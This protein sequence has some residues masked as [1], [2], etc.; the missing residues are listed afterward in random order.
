MD[1]VGAI[2]TLDPLKILSIVTTAEM[3][4]VANNVA[5][6]VHLIAARL[7]DSPEIAF[8]TGVCQAAG[9][10]VVENVYRSC[11]KT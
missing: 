2:V 9:D 8:R 7:E 3:G 11:L 1:A 5:I 10:D 4:I 6:N